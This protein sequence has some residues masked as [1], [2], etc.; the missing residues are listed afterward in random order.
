MNEI[1]NW[2]S[3]IFFFFLICVFKATSQLYCVVLSRTET[4]VHPQD[5][6]ISSKSIMHE[7]SYLMHTT[8][9]PRAHNTHFNKD[10]Q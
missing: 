1:V 6:N 2:I 7:K 3:V 9:V 8:A 10:G 4:E 5:N